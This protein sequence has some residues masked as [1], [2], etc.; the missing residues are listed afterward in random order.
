MKVILS[1]LLLF[2]SSIFFYGEEN[3]QKSLT[4]LGFQ[5]PKSEAAAADFTVTDLN[6][7]TFKL[8]ENQDKVILFNQWATWC[9]PCRQEMPS[10]QR[11]YD[12]IKNPDFKIIAV[13]VGENKET[14]TDFLK[15]NK[16]TFPIMLDPTGKSTAEYS[17]GSIP[18]TYLIGKKGKILGRIVGGTE[19]DS[20]EFINIIKGL[21]K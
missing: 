6:G 14:V 15:K 10:I 11:L 1:F 2:V 16:Y 8:S 18:T 12:K 5:I 20:A 13:S 17:T 3:I 9:P 21:L 19:W 7:K 4:N